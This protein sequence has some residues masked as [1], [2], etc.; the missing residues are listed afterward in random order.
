M[1]SFQYA[2]LVEADGLFEDSG[3]LAVI[4]FWLLEVR[5]L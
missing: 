3:E 1:E 4:D 5:K 2:D